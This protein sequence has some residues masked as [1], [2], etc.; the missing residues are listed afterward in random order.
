[1]S[2]TI[3]LPIQRPQQAACTCRHRWCPRRIH[4][5][6][7]AV[8]GLFVVAHLA[9][10]L[11][12]LWPSRYQ[13]LVHQIHRLGSLLPV[14]ELTL[15]FIP[16]LAQVVYGLRM[17]V[18]VGLAYHTDKKSR[19]GAPR[20]FLQRL[21]AVVL[22]LFLG[23]HVAT[24]HRWGLHLLYEVSGADAL[25]SY[26]AAG[27]FHPDGQ[28][29]SSTA[30]A[31]RGGWIRDGVGQPVNLAVVAFYAIGIW[32]AC[33]HLANGLATA[34]MSLG[35][36]VTEPAQ[37]RWAWLCLGMGVALTFAGTAAWY[38]FTFGPPSR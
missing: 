21:S 4:A 2:Q 20:F 15:I 30:M 23:F 36:T 31:L 37:R 26:K 33:Y 22:L 28:A 1:V 27:L 16:L 29:Y 3:A 38:A 35:I 9:I 18:K 8:L 10:A 12:G 14:I 24:M 25:K 34:A 5:I 13:D 11:T 19:G 17:L 6:L 32:A 7:G